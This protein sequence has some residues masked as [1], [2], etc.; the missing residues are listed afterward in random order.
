MQYWEGN[1]IQRIASWDLLKQNILSE[2]QKNLFS[3]KHLAVYFHLMADG[4]QIL[5]AQFSEDIKS[6]NFLWSTF[7]NDLATLE[8]WSD[9]RGWNSILS[10]GR[11]YVSL[12]KY[13]AGDNRK[14]GIV[15]GYS[16][17]Q[18]E[19]ESTTSCCCEKGKHHTGVYKQGRCLQDTFLL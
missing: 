1:H 3:M 14:V 16:R 2:L 13:R 9:K 4:T 12:H 10:R 19:D 17:S 5:P 18:S 8:K 15:R 7:Y 6:Y 11:K